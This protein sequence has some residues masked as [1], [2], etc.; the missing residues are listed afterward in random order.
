MLPASEVRALRE[1]APSNLATLC[2]KAV[3]RLVTASDTGVT[4]HHDQQSGK[5]KFVLANF[6]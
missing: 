2:Y 1:A 6:I 3:E 4:T 5:I